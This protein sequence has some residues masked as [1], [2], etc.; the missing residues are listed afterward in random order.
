M[1]SSTTSTTVDPNRIINHAI[2]SGLSHDGPWL[3]LLGAAFFLLIGALV[4]T[5][6]R[7][8]QRDRLR[9]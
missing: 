4:L 7:R 1:D 8:R 3:I 5:G 2:S 9:S 6:L